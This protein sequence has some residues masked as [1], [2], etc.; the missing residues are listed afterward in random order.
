MIDRNRLLKIDETHYTVRQSGKGRLWPKCHKKREDYDSAVKMH[1]G[2]SKE[3]ANYSAVCMLLGAAAVD[4]DWEFADSLI[5]KYGLKEKGIT[6]HRMRCT[7][8]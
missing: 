8:I 3:L 1:V 5:D 7:V 2:T 4:Y 6:P